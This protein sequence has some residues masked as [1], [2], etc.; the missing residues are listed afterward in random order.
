MAETILLVENESALRDLMRRFLEGSGYEVLNARD[1]DEALSV[2]T[3]HPTP[4]DLLLTD[5]V[6]PEMRG[7]EVARRAAG[8]RPGLRVLF[9][10][11]YTDNSIG[12]DIAES[13]SFLQ[14]PFTLADLLEGA[15]SALIAEPLRRFPQNEPEPQRDEGELV[16][17]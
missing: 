7:V 10:S 12:V 16:A 13:V 17:L 11:G 2:V 1:G 9:M 3:T 14:K 15:R 8:I 4:I 6:M 5:V